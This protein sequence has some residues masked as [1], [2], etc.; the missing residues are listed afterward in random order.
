MMGIQIPIG[1]SSGRDSSCP[2]E[3]VGL[4]NHFRESGST[5][6]KKTE[7]IHLSE[8]SHSWVMC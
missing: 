3:K 4:T 5:A 1:V 8:T 2:K 7:G 6:S